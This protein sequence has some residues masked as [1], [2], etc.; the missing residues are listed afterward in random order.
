MAHHVCPWWMG[1]IL[2]NPLRRLIHNPRKIL[3]PCIRP[4]MTVLDIGSG[5]GFFSLPMANLVGPEGKV[6]ALDLQPE[7]IKILSRRATKAGLADRID[8]RICQ[9]DSLGA[10]NMSGKI[11]FALAF[12]MVHEVPDKSGFMNQIHSLLAPE[13]KLYML[14]PKNHVT[15]N[16]F[17]KTEAEAEKAGF[18]TLDRPAV[19]GSRTLL[20]EKV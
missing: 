1:Y 3:G 15:K 14:E 12:Y 13:G 2:V 10:E 6:L 18:K 8:A 16:E 7:M 11:N 20:M 19:R 4:G 9:S 5:M 17:L